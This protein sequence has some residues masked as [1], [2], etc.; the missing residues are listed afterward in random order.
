[1]GPRGHVAFTSILIVAFAVDLAIAR[2]QK[3]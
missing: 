3:S 1:M 2:F